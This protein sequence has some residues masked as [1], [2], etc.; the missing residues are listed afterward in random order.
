MTGGRFSDGETT[1]GFIIN[2]DEGVPE[3]MYYPLFRSNGVWWCKVLKI[4]WKE[5]NSR[6]GLSGPY[7]K[8]TTLRGTS[9]N[10]LEAMHQSEPPHQWQMHSVV[11]KLPDQ[12]ATRAKTEEKISSANPSPYLCLI[13]NKE[14]LKVLWST[15]RV[16]QPAPL[17]L[18]WSHL[19]LNIWRSL[20]RC[21]GEN[22][23]VI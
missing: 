1:W 11:V 5:F 3:L 10:L 6:K 7:A 20:P 16:I 2:L 17:C 9:P 23:P 12:A 8:P 21:Q 22:V 15:E 18:C 4:V 19:I 13:K 14:C